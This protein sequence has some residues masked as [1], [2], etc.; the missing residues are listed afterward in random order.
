[1]AAED[2]DASDSESLGSDSDAIG[3]TGGASASSK[4]SCPSGVR[5]NSQQCFADK[6]HT[7]LLLDW[8]D[9]IFPTTWVK[10]DCEMCWKLSIDDQLERGSLR[11][12]QIVELLEKHLEKAAIF[13]HEANCYANVFIVT[14]ARKPWVEMSMDNFLPG[15]KR[16]VSN[17]K[18]IY[19]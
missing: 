1:M 3:G 13:L 7:T 16:F 19:A 4:A 6:M 10:K 18:I 15:L 14:L 2:V 8:D 17:Y 5:R 9:T 12:K 11:K